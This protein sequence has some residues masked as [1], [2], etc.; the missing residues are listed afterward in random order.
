[1]EYKKQALKLPVI[2]FDIITAKSGEGLIQKRHGDL[3]PN[4]IR[5]AI[6]GGSNCVNHYTNQNMTE[7]KRDIVRELHAPA[8]RNFPRRKVDIRDKDETWQADLVDMIEHSSVNSGYK[9]ILTIID[10]FSKF[11]WAVELKSKTGREVSAAMESIFK[12]GRVCKNL[13]V[14]QGTELYNSIFKRC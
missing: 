13:H 7:F 4:T 8:R 9:Y 10:I 2:N 5:C 14:D 11:S 6:I 3:L 1:M 12:K